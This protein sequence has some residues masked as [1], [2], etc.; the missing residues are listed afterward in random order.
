MRRNQ[1]TFLRRGGGRTVVRIDQF[2]I[3]ST[4]VDLAGDWNPVLDPGIF[5]EVLVLM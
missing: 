3:S 5:V 2:A 4:W 1:A